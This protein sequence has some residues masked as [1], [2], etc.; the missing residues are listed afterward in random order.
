MTDTKTETLKTP[1]VMLGH[2][3]KFFEK[4]LP[5]DAGVSYY[6]SDLLISPE[7]QQTAEFAK[8]KAAQAAAAKEKWPANMP[9]NLKSAFRPAHEKK[10]QKDGSAYYPAEDFPGWLLMRV[11]TKNQP[12]IASTIAGDDGKVLMITDPSEIYGG[13]FVRCSVNPNAYSVKGNNGVSFWLN[14]V[15]KLRDGE[16]LGGGSRTRAADDF[17]PVGDAAGADVDAMF[18]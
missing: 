15:Q 12:Q 9:G 16:P 6:E 1:E 13:C 7:A 10:R 8:L 14:N 11:K 4:G 5:D 2:W 18:T 3:P 17:E